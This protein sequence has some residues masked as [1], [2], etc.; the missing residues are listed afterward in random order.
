MRI[1]GTAYPLPPS[2]DH[3]QQTTTPYIQNNQPL[4]QHQ[5]LFPSR[6]Q[7]VNRHTPNSF[8][9][10]ELGFKSALPISSS[11]TPP[12]I[13]SPN[14]QRYV[15]QHNINVPSLSSPSSTTTTPGGV[16]TTAN[17]GSGKGRLLPYPP[18][19]GEAELFHPRPRI[20][21]G[22]GGLAGGLEDR[23][24]GG[25]GGGG[26]ES[27]YCSALESQTESA[28][29]ESGSSG[30][31]NEEASIGRSESEIGVENEATVEQDRD[32]V[33][34][35][36]KTEEEEPS[37]QEL[38]NS[39]PQVPPRTISGVEAWEM[40]LGETVKRISTSGTGGAG[41][42]LD[43][44]GGG[45]KAGT[46]LGKREMK[47]G[48]KM[49]ISVLDAELFEMPDQVGDFSLH[50][51]STT[52]TTASTS[53]F[54]LRQSAIGERESLIAERESS[55]DIRESSLDI[56]ESSLA[57]RESSLD[58]R[59]SSITTRESTFTTLEAGLSTDKSELDQRMINIQQRESN[60]EKRES[61]VRQREEKVEERETEVEKRK[62]EVEEWY[63]E[64]VTRSKWSP[65]PIEFARRLF[66]TFLLPVLGEER[67]P[68]F[69]LPSSS[70]ASTTTTVPGSSETNFSLLQQSTRITPYLISSWSIKR[71]FILNR[72]LGRGGGGG[73]FVLM[74]IG[75]CVVF[76]RGFVRRILRVGGVGRR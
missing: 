60:V 3:V 58:I 73:Y 35:A 64:K 53:T 39:Q 23:L 43:I 38:L 57:I 30:G 40:D 8:D 18:I 12:P 1:S 59:E 42:I 63:Q 70:S 72:V 7:S 68:R 45:N 20:G 55:L 21:L 16:V 29:S 47:E 14:S 4:H 11:P 24:D 54:A 9:Y 65:L 28:D 6:S 51:S 34:D 62:K 46:K 69:L 17:G 76:L 61:E 26:E 71:D 27:V 19:V 22:V 41:S 36:E 37:I 15:V 74:S 13:R 2:P 48:G 10:H 49:T 66:A 25:G 32:G 52:T 31:G 67:T 33:K 5:Y 75:I 44:G 50:E 56:R